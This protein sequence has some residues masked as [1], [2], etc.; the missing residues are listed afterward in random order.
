MAG[1]K[2]KTLK[3]VVEEKQQVTEA[4]KKLLSKEERMKLV[5]KA[6]TGIEKKY[7]T[8]SVTTLTADP[9]KAMPHISSGSLLLDE[10]LGIGGYPK[11]RII[12]IY[13]VESSG[14]TTLTLHLIAECQ[15][16]G[17]IA[18]F[19][20][21]EH[22]L[23][24]VYAQAL[25]VNLDELMVSQPDNG[26]QALEI[27]EAYVR[28]G[29]VDVIIVDSVAA[30]IPKAEIEGDM[31][32]ATM[33]MQAR[34]M[35]QACRKLTAAV[36]KSG[37]ILVFINQIR[38][39]IGVMH[40]NPETTTGGNALKFYASV[41]LE[42]RKT[43]KET[44]GGEVVAQ[45]VKIKVVKNKVAPPFK[46]VETSITFGRGLDMWNEVVDF[47]IS[48][49]VVKQAGAWFTYNGQRFQGKESVIKY[50]EANP[51]EF[52]A[53]QT[54]VYHTLGMVAP[55]ETLLEAYAEVTEKLVNEPA[56]T[57]QDEVVPEEEEGVEEETPQPEQPVERKRKK[58]E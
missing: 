48:K 7:G 25:G 47:A 31:G 35:S 44:K 14:K 15:R 27:A 17:G 53:L 2:S 9:N 30:L 12:E 49:D 28:S 8:G 54:S 38:M 37:T 1:K 29:G 56:E 45:G 11:G 41:R 18:A 55:D 22:A 16:I 13:G 19:I 6:N 24:P 33:G 57:Y 20:D 32:Q 46:Q 21:A 26:E 10:A 3:D 5:L 40:G 39:K 34:L 36:A 52:K 51:T 50:L 43:E 4:E 23:D 58:K 42:V